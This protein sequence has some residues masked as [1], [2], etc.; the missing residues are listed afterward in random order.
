M[1]VSG[2]TNNR[3]VITNACPIFTL[4]GSNNY[5]V[6]GIFTDA[7]ATTSAGTYVSVGNK[8]TANNTI[9]TGT[10]TLYASVTDGTY[11]HSTI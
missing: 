11:I 1:L 4:A 2:I 3:M 8:F 5:T 7:G 9:P 10:Q 6:S